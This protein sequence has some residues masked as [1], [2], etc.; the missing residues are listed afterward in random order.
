MVWPRVWGDELGVLCAGFN[1]DLSKI[2]MNEHLSETPRLVSCIMTVY[3]QE[4]T[5]REAVLSTLA[6][7]YSPLEIIVSDD[8]S[9]DAT[10]QI[11]QEIAGGYDGPHRLVV[12]RNDQNL[13]IAPHVGLLFSLC[14][15][16][17]VCG[18]GGDDIALPNLAK[19]LM[20]AWLSLKC[21]PDLI[22]FP[23][24]D[25][26]ET[27]ACH[28]IIS[29]S[30]LASY[31]TVN[32]WAN[33]PPMIIG[34]GLAYSGRIIQKY[35][36][37]FPP[38]LSHEDQLGVFRGIMGNGG[39]TLSSPLV[40]YRRGGISRKPDLSTGVALKRKVLQDAKNDYL[41]YSQVLK[42]AGDMLIEKHVKRMLKI[43][44]RSKYLLDLEAASFSRTVC[45]TG[46]STGV[47]L[48]FRIRAL[49]QIRWPE[50]PVK[51][52]NIKNKIKRKSS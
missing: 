49:M 11:L 17:F 20:T 33:N 44:R 40:K 34:A 25:M 36:N 8:C 50:L 35:L 22:A 7:T 13:G 23:V 52:R 19:D 42:E 38:G 32:E 3:N 1:I 28:G 15:G 39:V 43:I 14:H 45:M 47:D 5:V 2:A 16:D 41:F 12:R 6:Q 26:D 30:D 9:S 51:I 4:K 31:Q 37:D 18:I 48:G 21:R 24:I 27:G 46:Y 10:W 29:V